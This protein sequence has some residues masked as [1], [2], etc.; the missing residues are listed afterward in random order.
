MHPHCEVLPLHI[1]RGN[2]L[3][4]WGA[5]D[6]QFLNACAFGRAVTALEGVRRVA[7][8]FDELGI[9]NVSAKGTFNGLKISLVTVARKMDTVS[10]ALGKIVDEPSGA[11]AITTANKI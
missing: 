8:N 1:R 4:I 3:G 6:G 10:E 11:I 9:V 7:I 2:V 5:F